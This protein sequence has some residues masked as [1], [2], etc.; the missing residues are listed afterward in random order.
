MTTITVRRKRKQ[1]E[2]KER[3]DESQMI[4][5]RLRLLLHKL[6]VLRINQT[7]FNSIEFIKKYRV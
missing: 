7:G 2:V 5:M 3:N 4:M 1:Q 6:N